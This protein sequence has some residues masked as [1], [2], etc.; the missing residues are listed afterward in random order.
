MVPICALPLSTPPPSTPPPL[1]STPDGRRRPRPVWRAE[2]RRQRK[3]AV[4][5]SAAVT[6]RT[7]E[8]QREHAAALTAVRAEANQRSALDGHTLERAASAHKEA[9]SRALSAAAAK[10]ANEMREVAARAAAD[11]EH[12][13]QAERARL[14]KQHHARLWKRPLARPSMPRRRATHA[15]AR[16]PFSRHNKPQLSWAEASLAQLSS[17]SQLAEYSAAQTQLTEQLEVHRDR[18]RSSCAWSTPKRA[19]RAPSSTLSFVM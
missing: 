16:R 17:R 8:L 9:L 5:L 1:T 3:H 15:S 2:P 14:V 13:L 11:Q 12:A 4:A 10:H 6:E 18:R 7:L 19:P